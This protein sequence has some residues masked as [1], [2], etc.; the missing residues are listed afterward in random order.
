MVVLESLAVGT[1][2][3]VMP[4]CGFAETLSNFEEDYVAKSEN[5]AGLEESF[6]SHI[7]G[8]DAPKSREEIREFCSKTF[9][10]AMVTDELVA[11]YMEAQI[12]VF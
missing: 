4:S 7:D 3:L 1:P 9:G 11:T 5:L 8:K 6:A 2:V 10:I 12:H